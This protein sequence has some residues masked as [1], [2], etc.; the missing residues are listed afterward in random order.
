MDEAFLNEGKVKY[1][2]TGTPEDD[3]FETKAEFENAL[4]KSKV[5]HVGIRD[6]DILVVG[7]WNPSNIKGDKSN[8]AKFAE[9]NGI[10]M[11]TYKNF[12]KK[13]KKDLKEALITEAPNSHG[14]TYPMKAGNYVI[15][16]PCYFTP[17][18]KW[19][20]LLNSC[21]IFERPEG[22]YTNEQGE[23]VNVLAFGTD[24]GDGNFESNIGFD[25]GVDAGLIGL[26][27][28]DEC[29]GL[30]HGCVF[31]EFPKD[32][33]CS[34]DEGTMYFGDVVIHTGPEGEDEDGEDYN[35]EEEP[36]EDNEE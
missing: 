19:D 25:F 9:K 22:Y 16:D 11:V 15:G 5:Q 27:P 21:E 30:P 3:G 28:S 6:A 2:M 23:K 36:E 14:E 8:K 1:E 32:F 29:D 35:D 10:K 13:F 4:D 20:E 31:H 12:A 24:S 17:E 26:M 7:A 33:V 34:Y 18:N